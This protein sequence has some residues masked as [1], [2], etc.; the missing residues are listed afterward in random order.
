[1]AKHQGQG[2]HNCR[3]V[4]GPRIPRQVARDRG[5]GTRVLPPGH[6][7]AG[8]DPPL[9]DCGGE[10]SGSTVPRES[11]CIII[12]PRFKLEGRIAELPHCKFERPLH[13]SLDFLPTKR[14]EH[15]LGKFRA[16]PR[17]T[18]RQKCRRWRRRPWSSSALWTMSRLRAAAEQ[19]A[20]G[21]S[22]GRVVWRSCGLTDDK[23]S[24]LSAGSRTPRTSPAGKGSWAWH[25]CASSGSCSRWSRSRTA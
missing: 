7:R 4:Q 6:V 11:L 22:C 3:Q 15:Y 18:L 2:L 1:V 25:T 10:R 20:C 5:P 9:H 21:P 14:S 8:A 13:G 17:M 16:F 24:S 12:L 23:A 19:R